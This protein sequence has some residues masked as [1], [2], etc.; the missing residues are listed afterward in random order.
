[1]VFS[2]VWSTRLAKLELL[3]NFCAVSATFDAKVTE[4][5]ETMVLFPLGTW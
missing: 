4:L 2:F 5:T 1:M 3:K